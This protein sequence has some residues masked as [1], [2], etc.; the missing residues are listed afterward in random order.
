MIRNGTLTRLPSNLMLSQVLPVGDS[1]LD[2][3][4]E[5]AGPPALRLELQPVQRRDGAGGLI[6]E[7]ASPTALAA[8]GPVRIIRE[9]ERVRAVLRANGEREEVRAQVLLVRRQR[10]RLA[11]GEAQRNLVARELLVLLALAQRD[12]DVENHPRLTDRVVGRAVGDDDVAFVV[13]GGPN[14]QAFH[15]HD[16]RHPGV[17]DLHLGC[18]PALRETGDR[19]RRDQHCHSERANRKPGRRRGVLHGGLRDAACGWRRRT[20]TPS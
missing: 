17:G 19:Q 2:R 3:E 1:S 10:D 18:L 8:P 6:E 15:R 20:T 11:A 13:V 12:A 5:K 4:V 14:E 9:G 7:E 16:L